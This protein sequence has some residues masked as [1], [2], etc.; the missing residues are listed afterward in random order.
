MGITRD[1]SEKAHK[2]LI[3]TL[4]AG[5]KQ[6]FTPQAKLGW[7]SLYQQTEAQIINYIFS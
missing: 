4:E 6:S 3:M 5:L 1:M 7:E 2:C